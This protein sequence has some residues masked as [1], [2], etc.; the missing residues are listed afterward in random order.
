MRS[1]NGSFDLTM[2][3]APGPVHLGGGRA[4]SGL[5]YNG[6]YVP[7]TLR[8]RLGDTLR[9]ATEFFIGSGEALTQL[10]SGR[11]RG[12]PD[13]NHLIPERGLAPP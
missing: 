13:A 4:F 12:I 9:K 11:G 7:P 10:R 1:A 6:A 5:L 8:V 2:T 3:A